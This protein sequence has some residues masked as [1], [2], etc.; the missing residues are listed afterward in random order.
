M[1]TTKYAICALAL[2]MTA[3]A[4][5]DTAS[6]THTESTVER[7]GNDVTHTIQKETSNDPDGLGN[8]TWSK[9]EVKAKLKENGDSKQEV[10]SKSVDSAGTAHR[11][12]ETVA[13]TVRTDGTVQTDVEKDIVTDPKGL[14]NKT[15][16]KI[17]RTTKEHTDGT[18]DTTEKVDG[19]TVR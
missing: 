6:K 1:K 9:E 10:T 17:E 5:A 15:K 18:V 7:N 14:G 16:T 2:M 8:K 13:R 11:V 4:Y 12:D 3:S 19:K